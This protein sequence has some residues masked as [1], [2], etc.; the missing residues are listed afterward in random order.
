[1]KD[2]ASSDFLKEENIRSEFPLLKNKG[3]EFIYLDTAATS[4]KP[5][6]VLKELDN[7]YKNLNS[8]VHR[9]LYSLSEKATEAFEYSRSRVA[10]FINA[11]Y[12]HEIIFTKGA[13]EAINL[14]ALSWGEENIKEGDEIVITILEHHSNLIPW[15]RLAYKK[16]AKLKIIY[17]NKQGVVNGF[18]LSSQISEKTKLVAFTHISNVTGA[19]LPIKELTEIAHRSGAYV[20]IDAAQ[21]VGHMLIDV[22]N[23]DCDWLVFSGHKMYGPTGVGILYGKEAVLNSTSPC[24]FGGGMVKEV[25]LSKSVWDDLPYKYEAG[26][27]PLAEAIALK[28]A[29]EFLEDQGLNSIKDREKD[30]TIYAEKE[31]LSLGVEVIGPPA[32]LDKGPIISFVLPGVHAHDVVYLAGERGV[33]LRAGHHCAE[34]LHREL[35]I[36]ASCRVSLG[37]Y[38]RYFDI[39]RLVEVLREVKRTFKVK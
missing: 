24:F 27:P 15:Q 38:N 11:R 2:K 7:F 13:T 31:L 33:C 6:K 8:N 16:N 17:P 19:V 29:V 25:T 4:H 39:D 37:V 3:E 32:D 36:S 18:K 20:L 5:Y 30:L 35:G 22:Q 26:T 10:N 9:G 12:D 21:S 34:P 14:V 28:S 1:M 23:I